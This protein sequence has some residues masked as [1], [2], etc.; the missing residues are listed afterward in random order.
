[1]LTKEMVLN[2]VADMFCNHMPF[3]QFL[4]IEVVEL[5]AQK[6]TIKLPWQDAL[7]GNPIQK[8]MHGGVVSAILD[9]VGGMLAAASVIDKLETIDMAVLTEKL[10]KAGTIDMRTDYLRPGKGSAFIASAEL[11]RAGNKVCVCRME[12]HNDEGVQI[13]FGTGTYLVG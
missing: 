10:G 1:M 8:I 4:Q 11:I 5:T 6:A 9:N 12:M 7:I 2:Q 3:N 13:A